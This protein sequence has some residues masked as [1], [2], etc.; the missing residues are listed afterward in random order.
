MHKVAV[1]AYQDQKPRVYFLNHIC[2]Q[3]RK[4][5]PFVTNVYQSCVFL[6][7]KDRKATKKVIYYSK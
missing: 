6:S 3:G 4:R 5:Y 2:N 1:C 7:S